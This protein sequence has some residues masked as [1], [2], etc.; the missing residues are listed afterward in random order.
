MVPTELLLLSYSKC[1]SQV[2]Q[3]KK[4]EVPSEILI[5]NINDELKYV[6]NEMFR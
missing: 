6:V 5:N 4:A 2:K 1:L 3:K